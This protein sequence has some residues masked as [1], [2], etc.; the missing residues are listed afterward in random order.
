MMC[1][2]PAGAAPHIEALIDLARTHGMPTWTAYGGF[3]RPWSRRHLDG[4]DAGLSE[5]RAGIA[6]CREQ[7]VGNFI[8]LAATALAE[9]EVEAGEIEAALATI[10]RVIADRSARDSV[11]LMRRATASAAIF[12]TSAIRRI[13]RQPRKRS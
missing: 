12:C 8:R 9:G 13:P 1:R 4:P 6:A 11:G 3:L 5:M 2:N 10:D 7:R